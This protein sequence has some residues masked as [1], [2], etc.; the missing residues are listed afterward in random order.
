MQSEIT[1]HLVSML[2]VDEVLCVVHTAGW[3]VP[4]I[5]S[6][7]DRLEMHWLTLLEE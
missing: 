6:A 5:V 4:I 2:A 1:L 3:L 7:V